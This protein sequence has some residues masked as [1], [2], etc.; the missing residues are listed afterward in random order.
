MSDYTTPNA[1][2]GGSSSRGLFIALIVIILFVVG[3][4]AI[5]SDST[6]ATDGATEGAV[7]PAATD[8]AAA[9]PATSTVTE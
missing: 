8:D 5:G 4:A 1:Q 2:S 3:L 7:A 9:A 6:P